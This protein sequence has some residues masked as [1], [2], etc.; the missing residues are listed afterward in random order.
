M[1]LGQEEIDM[2]Q[3]RFDMFD[4]RGI[5]LYSYFDFSKYLRSTPFNFTL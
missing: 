2:I 5:P 4:K 1:S 3:E